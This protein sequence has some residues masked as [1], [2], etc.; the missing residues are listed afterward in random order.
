MKYICLGYMN[1]DQASQMSE[2]EL[3]E[4]MKACF[5]Y[6]KELMAQG[7]W[8]GGEGLQ[9][10][11]DGAALRWAANDVLITDGPFIESKEHIGGILII[12]ARDLNH[13]IRILSAHPSLKL[14][15]G[16]CSWEIRA[17]ADLSAMMASVGE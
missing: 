10:A 5:V 16:A 17:A 12:E 8:K 4:F 3:R 9:P 2:D 11:S 14:G 13:A 1:E 15:K 6:D 7:I